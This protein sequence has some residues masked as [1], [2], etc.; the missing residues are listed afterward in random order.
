[1]LFLYTQFGWNWIPLV[2]LLRLYQKLYELYRKINEHS[3]VLGD[4]NEIVLGM[5]SG[6]GHVMLLYI[7][8]HD[9]DYNGILG[10]VVKL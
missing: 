1:M 7:T 10:S 2:R 3:K 5:V 4:I 9:A 6:N 8:Q